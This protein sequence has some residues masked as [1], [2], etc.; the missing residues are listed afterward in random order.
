MLTRLSRPSIWR[1]LLVAG[2]LIAFQGYLAFSVVSGQFGIEN[3][4]VIEADIEEL[5]A[6]S[7]A[8]AVEIESVGHR[9]TLFTPQKLD[10]DIVSERA[11]ALLAMSLPTEVIVMV[12]EDGELIHSSYDTLAADQ[13][14]SLIVED[15]DASTGNLIEQ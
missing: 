7:A 8:L 14:T 9:S 11:R 12:D 10:P 3:S 15:S 5:K 2:A 13:L 6:T 1:Q 4:E